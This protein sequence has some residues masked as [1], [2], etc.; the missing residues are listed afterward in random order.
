MLAA[1]RVTTPQAASKCC[2]GLQN[3]VY[4]LHARSLSSLADRGGLIALNLIDLNE[5]T[6]RL[7]HEEIEVDRKTGNVYLSPRLPRRTAR[8]AQPS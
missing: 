5:A 7:M 4:R 3:V 8:L 2:Y 1:R 6:R